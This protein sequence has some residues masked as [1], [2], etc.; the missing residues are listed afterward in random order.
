MPRMPE[1]PV[2]HVSYYEADAFAELGRGRSS[3]LLRTT[4]TT[5]KV[6]ADFSDDPPDIY[7]D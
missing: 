5:L 3:R 1:A 7:G 2:C 6:A 4:L